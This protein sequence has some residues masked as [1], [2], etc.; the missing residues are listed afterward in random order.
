MMRSR[1]TVSCRKG[2][3]ALAERVGEKKIPSDE[4]IE[5]RIK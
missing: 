2:R 4:W 3:T 5:M 1:L